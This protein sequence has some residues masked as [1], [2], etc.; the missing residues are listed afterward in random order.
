MFSILLAIA[1]LPQLHSR[2]S[3][4]TGHGQAAQP[5]RVSHFTFQGPAN[6]KHSNVIK[7]I[8][9][10]SLDELFK[11]KKTFQVSSEEASLVR[12][13]MPS[14][15]YDQVQLPSMTVSTFCALLNQIK[16]MR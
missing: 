12:T 14:S 8:F 10:R 4:G 1:A 13:E 6:R 11:K 15:I 7:V 3:R 9:T 5:G 16:Q 2:G